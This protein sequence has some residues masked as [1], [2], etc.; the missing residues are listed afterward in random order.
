MLQRIVASVDLP[1]VPSHT[2]PPFG[3]FQS[4]ARLSL[5]PRALICMQECHNDG[6]VERYLQSVLGNRNS[7]SP[8]QR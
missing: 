4:N 3:S 2:Q 7:V 1:N 8:P 5:E 6:R